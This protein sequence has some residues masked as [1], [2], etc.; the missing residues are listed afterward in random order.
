MR[1]T[2]SVMGLYNYDDSIFDDME[3]PTSDHLD[4][5][6]LI[7]NIL[8]EC[9]ELEI[10]YT[11]PTFFK[12][13]LEIWSKARVHV[14]QKLADTMDYEYNPIWN[15]DVKDTEY[16]KRTKDESTTYSD[17]A[18]STTSGTNTNKGVAF[19]SNDL[20]NREQDQTSGSM[21]SSD[22][23][24]TRDAGYN[25][26]DREYI[27]QGNQGVTSTQQLIKEEREV[28]QFSLY[29]IIISEFKTRF[30]LLVY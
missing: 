19:N 25:D 2:L 3:L 8:V 22:N 6:T 13:I 4:K 23:S 30:C 18:S 29:D 14:W 16:I 1:G 7:Q 5:D 27:S 15:K 21:S 28:S 24:T 20:E 26:E 17:T 10:L 9:S 12:K 11:D